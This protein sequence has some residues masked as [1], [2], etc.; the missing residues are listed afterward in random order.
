MIKILIF[1]LLFS[2]GNAYAY[3]LFAIDRS[4]DDKTTVIMKYEPNGPYTLFQELQFRELENYPI[5]RIEKSDLPETK[6]DRKYWKLNDVPIGKKVI[7]DTFKKQID[8]DFDIAEQASANAA[9]AKMCPSC[10]AQD[11]K[12]MRKLK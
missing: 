11:L 2:C 12:D 7:V 4:A 10:T 8:L 9:L 6:I 5:K 1:L 3:D